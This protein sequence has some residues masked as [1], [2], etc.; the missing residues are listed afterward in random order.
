MENKDEQTLKLLKETREELFKEADKRVKKKQ[1]DAVEKEI[2]PRI[3]AIRKHTEDLAGAIAKLVYDTITNATR[4]KDLIKDVDPILGRLS[5]GTNDTE[6]SHYELDEKGLT[7]YLNYSSEYYADESG[8][9]RCFLDN[10]W[11]IDFSYLLF[12][13]KKNGI[14]LDRKK[15]RRITTQYSQLEYDILTISYL[16]KE[17]DDT[18]GLKPKK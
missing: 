14:D 1:D 5:S 10:N 3:L 16:R 8:C 12:I 6:L 9:G 18:I 13:L 7:I 15:E 17:K 2:D 4:K 11:D